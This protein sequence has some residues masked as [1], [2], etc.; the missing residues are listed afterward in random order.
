[1]PLR[2]HQIKVQRDRRVNQLAQDALNKVC[3][4]LESTCERGLYTLQDFSD[5]MCEIFQTQGDENVYSVKHIKRQ[6]E[7]NMENICSLLKF[8]NAKMCVSRFLQSFS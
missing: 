6:L 8:W 7:N 1:M 5:M 2:E 4:K 3:D